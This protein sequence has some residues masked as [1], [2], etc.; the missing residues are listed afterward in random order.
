MKMKS[1]VLL[2]VAACLLGAGLHSVFSQSTNPPPSY[3]YVIVWYD[4]PDNTRVLHGDGTA[5]KL[6]SLLKPIKVPNDVDERKF[7]IVIA[8]N[9]LIKDGY[10]YV[11]NLDKDPLM[12]RPVSR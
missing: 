4:G 9:T 5:E 10:E 2:A 7:H 12:R 3:E 1:M 11:G 6:A 8:I